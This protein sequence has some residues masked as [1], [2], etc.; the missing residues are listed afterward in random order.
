ML[1][2][3]PPPPFG[4]LIPRLVIL[5]LQCR[6]VANTSCSFGLRDLDKYLINLFG[7]MFLL[8]KGIFKRNTYF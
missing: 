2:L 3:A 1:K 7:G 6:L 4:I 8:I 5:S